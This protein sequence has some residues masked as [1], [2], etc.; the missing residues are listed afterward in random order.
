MPQSMPRLVTCLNQYA[1]S[2]F[3]PQRIVVAAFYAEVCC[4]T[5][6]S[7]LMWLV[8]LNEDDNNN[9]VVK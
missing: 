7:I 8:H 5:T 3:E 9:R 2:T 4:H 1:T 6:G